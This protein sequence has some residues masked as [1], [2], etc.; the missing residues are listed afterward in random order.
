M[1]VGLEQLRKEAALVFFQP[2]SYFAL[3]LAIVLLV[4]VVEIVFYL[5]FTGLIFRIGCI[6]V[7]LRVAVEFGTVG[8]NLCA[9]NPRLGNF[10]AVQ[11]TDTTY[12]FD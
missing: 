6:S 4:A 1:V 7:I 3:V 12:S 5:L 8:E 2:E 9:V 10:V 11:I